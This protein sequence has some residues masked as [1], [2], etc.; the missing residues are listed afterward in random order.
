M[1][2]IH[3]ND[4]DSKNELIMESALQALRASATGNTGHQNGQLRISGN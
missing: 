1:K 3:S 4:G 2:K